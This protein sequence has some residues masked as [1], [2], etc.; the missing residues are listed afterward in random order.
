MIEWD[1]TTNKTRSFRL[2]LHTNKPISRNN[3]CRY[4]LQIC[5]HT[6]RFLQYE[7]DEEGHTINNILK[8]I[9]IFLSKREWNFKGN[10]QN[11]VNK[12]LPWHMSTAITPSTLCTE[13]TAAASL[14]FTSADNGS[15]EA[16]SARSEAGR[17]VQRLKWWENK[18]RVLEWGGDNKQVGRFRKT[19][20]IFLE[21][22]F[23]G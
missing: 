13:L 18:D 2:C 8:S 16:G 14:S 4:K 7:Q 15:S 22:G 21:N 1:S 11:S 5:G 17:R 10:T 23:L 3:N 20:S 19:T 12:L 6:V 9:S